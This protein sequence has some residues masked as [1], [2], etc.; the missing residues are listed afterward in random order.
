MVSAGAA[1]QMP[2]PSPATLVRGRPYPSQEN[3]QVGILTERES[4]VAALVAQ[5]LSN[6]TVAQQL[7]IPEGARCG[8]AL[9]TAGVGRAFN[10]TLH[11]SECDAATS[12]VRGI[13]RSST[14]SK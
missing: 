9:S 12:R 1:R 10:L 2:V 7:S 4:E 14:G 11:Q 13:P 8:M 6:K 3:E 5:G